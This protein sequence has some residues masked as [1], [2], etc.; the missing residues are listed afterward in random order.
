MKSKR[1]VIDI[2]SIQK[3]DNEN[4]EIKDFLHDNIDKPE[5]LF[6][7]RVSGRTKQLNLPVKPTF[8]Q[9][10]KTISA[11]EARPMAAILEDA[12][13]LYLTNS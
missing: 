6:D 12:L 8:H 3:T 11:K 2:L 5:L 10:L 9:Q 7:K 4:M 13:N 1:K